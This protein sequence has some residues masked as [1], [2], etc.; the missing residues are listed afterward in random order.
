MH[1]SLFAQFSCRTTCRHSLLMGATILRLD[2]SA[3]WLMAKLMQTDSEQTS[4][5]KPPFLFNNPKARIYGVLH[6]LLPCLNQFV[7]SMLTSLPTPTRDRRPHDGSAM[8]V[9]S[10]SVSASPIVAHS[11]AAPPNTLCSADISR[12][13]RADRHHYIEPRFLM[14]EGVARCLEASARV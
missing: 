5:L 14:H 13:A 6:M 3:N 11:F 4:C 9:P 7:A 1:E 12:Y 10:E 8:L 2:L